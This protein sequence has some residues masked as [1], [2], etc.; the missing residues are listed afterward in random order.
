MM[1]IIGAGIAFIAVV[2]I[3]GFSA[4]SKPEVADVVNQ[5]GFHIVAQKE[6]SMEITIHKKDLPEE[7]FTGE[8][9]EFKENEIILYEDGINTMYLEKVMYDDEDWEYLYF[10]INFSYDI[11]NYGTVMVPYSINIENDEVK[12][13]T[14]IGKL[15]S[16]DVQDKSGGIADSALWQ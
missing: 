4:F 6:A 12:D 5:N 3:I 2:S 13:F 7:C 9:H 14:M 11:F 10:G 8:G 15:D 1:Q 16:K